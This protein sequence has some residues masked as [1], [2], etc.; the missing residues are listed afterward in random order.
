MD[1]FVQTMVN[2]GTAIAV[3]AYFLFRDYKFNSELI[4]ILTTLKDLVTEMKNDIEK[5]GGKI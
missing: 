5:K 3:T 1:E 4:V 2:N